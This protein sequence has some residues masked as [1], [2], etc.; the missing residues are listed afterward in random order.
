MH[1]GKMI[2]IEINAL[3]IQLICHLS[4]SMT[5]SNAS[6]TISWKLLLLLQIGY[7]GVVFF[8]L[9]FHSR[10]IY[11]SFFFSSSC[12]FIINELQL[13]SYYRS[14]AKMSMREGKI[15]FVPLYLHFC[16]ACNMHGHASSEHM[17][18][19]SSLDSLLWNGLNAN[20]VMHVFLKSWNDETTDYTN[21]SKYYRSA[22]NNEIKHYLLLWIIHEHCPCS[23]TRSILI[24]PIE[25]QIKI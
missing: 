19:K 14:Q 11:S 15:D 8:L 17:W 9:P 6:H 7:C 1:A 21:R 2:E 22:T 5:H 25:W 12:V 23:I 16:L 18:Y 4:V 13:Y 20:F 24:M 3:T 10:P